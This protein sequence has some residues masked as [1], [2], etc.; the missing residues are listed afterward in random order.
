MGDLKLSRMGRI[1]V[2]YENVIL[3]VFK[4]RIHPF[5]NSEKK[6]PGDDRITNFPVQLSFRLESRQFLEG[7]R[8]AV[9]ES[10]GFVAA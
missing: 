8:S 9:I 6:C 3:G 2:R 5:R 7:N 1:F 4:I 10:L